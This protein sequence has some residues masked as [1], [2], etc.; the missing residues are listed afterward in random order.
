MIGF[1]SN[2]SFT[3]RNTRLKKIW[4]SNLENIEYTFMNDTVG[5]KKEERENLCS[6][7]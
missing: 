5:M 1:K 7:R 4:K 6:F 3:K 2:L